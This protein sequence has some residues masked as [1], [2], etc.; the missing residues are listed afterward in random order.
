M[1]FQSGVL[2]CVS[3]RSRLQGFMSP[4]SGCEA[5]T[6]DILIL[7]R[8]RLSASHVQ[9]LSR[10]LPFVFIMAISSFSQ[11]LCP[12]KI[13]CKGLDLFFGPEKEILEERL[14]RC[15]VIGPAAA[16]GNLVI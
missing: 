14:S 11:E 6:G 8:H 7:R 13:E 5:A 16:L 12:I 3:Q 2:T 15:R 10:C 4:E 1:D 9:P